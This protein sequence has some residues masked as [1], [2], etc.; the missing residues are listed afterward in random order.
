VTVVC[1]LWLLGITTSIEYDFLMVL[2]SVPVSGL[3]LW[4]VRSVILDLSLQLTVSILYN[5]DFGSY[6]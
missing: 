6:L 2:S 4:I 5:M 1:K 3:L